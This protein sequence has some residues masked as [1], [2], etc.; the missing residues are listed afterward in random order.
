MHGSDFPTPDATGTI[1]MAATAGKV[2]LDL[3]RGRPE[4]GL[5]CR[6][7]ARHRSRRLRTTANCAEGAPAPTLSNTRRPPREQ[8]S[9]TH[10]SVDF[11]RPA[12]RHQEHQVVEAA[13]PVGTELKI[14]EIQAP[15]TESPTRG[16]DHPRHRDR[17]PEY[18]TVCYFLSCCSRPPNPQPPRA[19]SSSSGR[20]GSRTS[21]AVDA[22]GTW[23][24]SLFNSPWPAT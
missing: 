16:R 17:D 4:R 24:G 7:H 19:S 9:T 21:G 1:A 15:V 6:L 23:P 2:A 11:T 20:V 12:T 14:D 3:E 18:C 8:R 13:P 5:S 22:V 10:S